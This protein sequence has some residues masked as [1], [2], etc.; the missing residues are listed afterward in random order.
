MTP[1]VDI[2]KM[3]K[4]ELDKVGPVN[5]W[6]GM[7][8]EHQDKEIPDVYHLADSRADLPP[9]FFIQSVHDQ[10]NP[11]A[12]HMLPLIHIYQK[13]MAW[14]GMR[15]HPAIGHRADASTKEAEYM[16]LNITKKKV[17]KKVSIW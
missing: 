16:F 11:F 6:T 7:I 9:L 12:E 4:Q 5:A 2:K 1:Q 17:Q 3:S 10:L 8:G 13:K 15:V 14:Y